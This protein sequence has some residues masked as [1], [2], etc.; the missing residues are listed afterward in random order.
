MDPAATNRSAAI[1][2]AGLARRYDTTEA[3]VGLDLSVPR[4]CC[5]ALLGPN[6]AGKTTAVS[7]L[8]TLLA[9]SSGS[10]RVLGRDV[11]RERDAVRAQIGIVFQGSSLDPQLTPR[12]HLELSAR[13]YR[14][15]GRARRVAELIDDFGLADCAGRPVRALSGGLRRRLEIARGILHA[16]PLLFLDEPTVGLDPAARAAVW[17]RLRALRRAETTLFLTTHSMEEADA[18][19]DEIGILDRGRLVARDSPRALKAELGGDSIWLRLERAG[20]AAGVLG[21]LADVV[22]VQ[23][24][25]EDRDAL[26]VTVQDGPRRLAQLLEVARPYGVV[27][28]ELHRPSLE[29]V[30]LH[31][32]GRRYAE[33]ELGVDP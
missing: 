10:A 3:L 20:E 33:A 5:F 28:V 18:L 29:Q 31:H 2:A 22:S 26:C 14:I 9:P 16:P 17:D 13:L 19:A 8:A 32:A 23:R 21:A 15:P 24:D 11:V 6:G 1:E 7:I 27:E 25:P 4:A 30:F 12:E